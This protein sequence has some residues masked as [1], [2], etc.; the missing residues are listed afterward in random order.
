M[1]NHEPT[2]LYIIKSETINH[3]NRK[4]NQIKKRSKRDH[5]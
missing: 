2:R 3:E 1:E 5:T 4:T